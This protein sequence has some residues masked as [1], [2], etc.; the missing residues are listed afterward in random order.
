M[1]IKFALHVQPALPPSIQVNA[2]LI[3]KGFVDCSGGSAFYGFGHI[4]QFHEAS[5]ILF[6]KVKTPR[7]GGNIDV[8]GIVL[9]LLLRL[10]GLGMLR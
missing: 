5:Q 1:L 10:N 6:T 3:W 4:F 2:N 8:V 7:N 9:R